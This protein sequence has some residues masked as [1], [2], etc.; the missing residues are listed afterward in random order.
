MT[1]DIRHG[2]VTVVLN[3]VLAGLLLAGCATR[4]TDTSNIPQLDGY[5]PVHIPDVDLLH[6]TPEMKKFAQAHAHLGGKVG[7]SAL[8]LAEA[9][10]DPELLDFEY[11]PLVTLTADEAFRRRKGNC[12]AYSA[13]Y[14]AMARESGIPAWFQEVNVPPQWS[15]LNDNLLVSK[16]INVMV[17]DGKED[18]TV[19][20]S[21]RSREALDVRRRL[22]DTEALAQYYNNQS[23]NALVFGNLP[24]AYA[25]VRKAL[26][27]D[28]NKS[29]LLSNLGIILKRNGQI[30]DA[31]RVF[32]TALQ[33]DSNETVLLNNLYTLYQERGDLAA[34]EEIGKRVERYRRKNPYYLHRM[35]ENLM[36]EHRYAE[37]IDLLEKAIRIE[38]EEYRFYYALA[39]S[40]YEAGMRQPAQ[41]S[42][43]RAIELATVQQQAQGALTL[44]END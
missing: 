3:A 6:L 40:Q 29:Y 22:T 23:V 13:M 27:I 10:L 21:S 36:Q 30:D 44:P 15:S 9:T 28:P 42:L 14:I 8:T 19:D 11:D 18:F 1:D 25:Y 2:A 12:L 35:A 33:Y 20:V 43:E 24:V 4:P 37:A 26:E 38:D 5:K 41:S 31:V 7:G 39:Q 17:L 16:H 32:E 34:A